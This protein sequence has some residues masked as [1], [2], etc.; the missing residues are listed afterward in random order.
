MATGSH[1]NWVKIPSWIA[2]LLIAKLAS[3]GLP[4]FTTTRL[5]PLKIRGRFGPLQRADIR[6]NCQQI[7]LG[8]HRP[9]KLF[10]YF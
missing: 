9:F 7:L 6:I 3:N 1:G 5:L 4:D 8:A 2:S 10:F